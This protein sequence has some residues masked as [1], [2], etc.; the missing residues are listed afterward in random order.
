M[1]RIRIGSDLEIEKTDYEQPAQFDWRAFYGFRNNVIAVLRQF[2]TAGPLGQVDLSTADD[3]APKFIGKNVDQPDFFVV[4]DMYNA[5]D[6]MSIVECAVQHI[7]EEVIQALVKIAARFPGWYVMINMGDSGL[8]V[9]GDQILVG[10]RRFWDCQDIAD[11]GRRC[12][13]DVDYGPAPEFQQSMYSLWVDLVCGGF[14]SAQNYPQPPDREW[15]EVL[16]LLGEMLRQGTKNPLDAFAYSRIRY[17]LHPYTRRRMLELFLAEAGSLPPGRL[18]EAV[19][20]NLSR[21]AADV[22][23]T[24]LSRE[25]VTSFAGKVSAVQAIAAGSLDPEDIVFWWPH[26]IDRMQRESSN[27]PREH[28]DVTRQALIAEMRTLLRSEEPWIQLSA[29]FSLAKLKDPDIATAVDHALRANQPWLANDP[30]LKWLL[31][32]RGGSASYPSGLILK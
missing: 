12:Q 22:L 30:L 14:S 28:S 26:I 4:D 15:T 32:I 13:S 21:D 18:K 17:D 2:G 25:D 3:E 10:G 16:R 9:F 19:K 23:A 20:R 29:V 11:I 6:K 31:K 5:H 27:R 1:S 8:R 24:S 7:S